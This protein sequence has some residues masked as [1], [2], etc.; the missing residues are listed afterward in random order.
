MKG[1][2]SA[3]SCMYLVPKEIYEKLLNL[4]DEREN[5][6]LCKLNPVGNED[7]AFP[8]LLMDPF[9]GPGRS[10]PE[11]GY[12]SS[13]FNRP[14]SASTPE[15]PQ[16]SRQISE[17]GLPR[18]P[19][20]FIYQNSDSGSS[21]VTMASIESAGSAYKGRNVPSVANIT[22][23]IGQVNTPSTSNAVKKFKYVCEM[24]WAS[25]QNRKDY[26]THRREHYRHEG[27]LII[28]GHEGQPST[29]I[30]RSDVDL[31]QSNAVQPPSHSPSPVTAAIRTNG[32]DSTGAQELRNY[33]THKLDN[34]DTDADDESSSGAGN[35][36]ACHLC[37]KQFFS[38]NLLKK[39]LYYCRKKSKVRK[40][41]R[42]TKVANSKAMKSTLKITARQ[43]PK[44]K[45]SS[46]NFNPNSVSIAAFRCPF[47]PFTFSIK[48]SLE[49]HM[50]RAHQID[51]RGSSLY[52]QGEKRN[53]E[54]AN[55]MEPN[56]SKVLKIEPYRCDV[57]N[58]PMKSKFQLKTHKENKHKKIKGG[59]LF[60][61]NI[62]STIFSGEKSLIRHLANIHECDKN[63]KS[64][65]PQGVKRTR[66]HLRC[67]ECSKKFA[68]LFDLESHVK[69]KHGDDMKYS[70]WA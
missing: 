64:L 19:D 28:Y 7:G 66:S 27:N 37:A 13:D 20:P 70:S 52:P 30:L 69:E 10:G 57:C 31:D 25:F 1:N 63:Y 26:D 29:G 65:M 42:P 18:A 35:D 15:Q 39:H 33:F 8:N 41:T 60:Q 38:L 5:R 61:C 46:L 14:A 2:K 17:T 67:S 68:M 11:D 54:K 21:D 36:H 6:Q 53:V 56:P 58:L 47:C 22:E 16:P 62:C 4:I 34:R 24:C 59:N 32:L 45:K 44:P 43:V 9:D 23:K 50:L 55:L 51:S 49:R 3:Y 12:G 40:N 48:N